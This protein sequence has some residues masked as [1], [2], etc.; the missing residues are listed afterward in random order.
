MYI[1]IYICTKRCLVYLMLG[2]LRN[3]QDE[4]PLYI[5]TQLFPRYSPLPPKEVVVPSLPPP[6]ERGGRGLMGLVDG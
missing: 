5:Y 1:Y 3:V 6:R 4:F 2:N